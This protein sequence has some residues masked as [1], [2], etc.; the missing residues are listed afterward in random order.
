MKKLVAV[1][2]LLPLLAL[3]AV[4]I[5]V[6]SAKQRWPWNNLVDIDF[7]VN[8]PAGEIYRAIIDAKSDSGGKVFS[9]STFTSDPMVKNGANRIT[10]DFGADY[11][12]VRVEDMK[13]TVS[14]APYSEAVPLYLKIDLSGGPDAA[15]YPVTYTFSA[16]P[17]VM[18]A[19]DEPCQT[20]EL[21]LRRIRH[22]EGPMVFHRFSYDPN[23]G[24]NFY[25]KLTKDY[26]FGVFELTQRQF[27]LVMGY[28][29]SFFSNKTCY[30]SR[31]V[32]SICGD[33]L[34]GGNY[35]IHRYPERIKE[36]SFF[37]KLRAKTGL[38]LTV[39]T[40]MQ[41][42]YALRGGYYGGEYYI[43]KLRDENGSLYKPKYAEI[44]RW[45]SNSAASPNG[46]SDTSGGTAAVG[47]YL[48]NMFGL[49]D[50]MGNVYEL[51]GE[52]V[53]NY[54]NRYMSIDLEILRT[55][56]NDPTLGTTADNPV[57]DYVGRKEDGSC[58]RTMGGS[59][60]SNQEVTI[61][62]LGWYMVQVYKGSTSAAVGVRVSM[63][64]E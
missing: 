24:N 19:A 41:F 49:Y 35:N 22:Y 44:G 15:K 51:T 45:Q 6:V 57:V 2:C 11:P 17:H 18:G 64:V 1:F 7:T 20:T 14:L 31:P 26:Y 42:E 55:E 13:V 40:S 27:E 12:N 3:Q 29:P 50:T 56:A 43:Y 25:G 52:Y 59:W 58:Y 16:P 36:A 5:S 21:W 61:W 53:K 34:Y 63:D 37:G 9:A 32:E 23:N 39:P 54:N 4:E 48:P 62:N 30:A 47:S 46:D 10:W 38:P 8:A 33:D 28:N 60:S